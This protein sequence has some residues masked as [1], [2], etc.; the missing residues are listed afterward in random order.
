MKVLLSLIAIFLI[1]CGSD[2]GVHVR[3]ATPDE[4]PNG[5]VTLVDGDTFPVCSNGA[6]GPK[7]DPGPAG[8][9][10][11]AGPPGP[12]GQGTSGSS[13]IIAG[14]VLCQ[15]NDGS[16]FISAYIWVIDPLAD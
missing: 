8:P 10:G 4:C 7:G 13:D 1:C 16:S 3:P 9:A 15:V 2:E 5:G 11:P 6:Q 12:A 14:T